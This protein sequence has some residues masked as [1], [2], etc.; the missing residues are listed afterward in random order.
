[1]PVE[2]EVPTSEPAITD[3][4]LTALVAAVKEDPTGVV[5]SVRSRVAAS[6]SDAN[7]CMMGG[8]TS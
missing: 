6:R 5:A 4:T 7:N 2:I 3:E 1:M 8:W